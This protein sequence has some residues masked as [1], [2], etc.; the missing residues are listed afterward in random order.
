MSNSQVSSDVIIIGCGISG[1]SV[2]YHLLF[3]EFSGRIIIL[4]SR[5]SIGGR[6]TST[7]TKYEN[8]RIEL[9]ANWIHGIMGN[10]IY[11]LAL[12]HKLIDQYSDLEGTVRYDN[13]VGKRLKA[14][15][16]SWISSLKDVDEEGKQLRKSVFNTLLNRETC[17]SGCHS[18]NE[19]SLKDFGSYTEL[20]GGNTTVPKGFNKIL[21]C[22]LEEI[23]D[24]VSKKSKLG[25]K[26]NL[27]DG[28][29]LSILKNQRVSK[30]NWKTITPDGSPPKVQVIC[31]NG[32]TYTSNH[33]VITLPLGVLKKESENLFEPKLPQYKMDA[34]NAIGFGTVN[35]IFL[36]YS[37]PLNNFIDVSV[38]ETIVLWDEK[39][40]P[41]CKGFQKIYSVSKI[42][43]HCLL[44]W[45][46]GKEAVELEK[47]DNEE[48][49]EELSQLLQQ[50]F[51]NSKLPKADNIV[52][53]RWGSDPFS[54]G[55]YSYIPTNS[56]NRDIELLSQPIYADPANDKP[57]ML[58]AGEA[59]H[60]SFYSTVH[61]AFLSG[62]KAA[63][64]L[65]DINDNM[66]SIDSNHILSAISKL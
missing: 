34:I 44:L 35:K 23:D 24:N 64:Y 66:S 45:A 36:E 8:H 18:M 32:S 30:I 47:M 31:D 38:D 21:N 9:G 52:V 65:Q 20:P 15:I 51:N 54:C 10:P 40:P 25:D 60:P 37:L 29:Q 62:R 43:N 1:L 7:F 39:N 13:S 59:T 16:D 63:Y 2:A 53:T 22:I 5:P 3:N 55:S 14:D 61:G 58:F 27:I 56:S 26:S 12:K 41:K 19:M 33:V 17:I 28:K 57:I 49:N 4:E 11:D 46:S 42:T 50:L 6:I 48:I